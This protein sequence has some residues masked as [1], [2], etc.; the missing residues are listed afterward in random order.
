VSLIGENVRLKKQGRRWVGLCPFH[1]ERTPSFSV[2]QERGLYYCFGCKAAGSAVDYLMQLEGM[3]FPE[4]IRALAERANI[5]IEESH[6]SG[7]Q[8]RAKQKRREKEELFNLNALCA[9]FFERQLREHPLADLAWEEIRR[10]GLDPEDETCAEALKAFR[11]GYA[12]YGWDGLAR[13]L[14]RQGIEP[15]RAA[16][17]GV[18]SAR[19]SGGGFFDAFRHRLMFAVSDKSGRVVAFSGRALKEPEAEV[20]SEHGIEPLFRRPD[21]ERRDPPKY[22]N[23]PESPI[24]VK[25]DNV[26]GL[27][28]ARRDVRERGQAV[29]VEGN[30]DVLSLHARGFRLA[31]APLGTAFTLGQARLIKRYA[32]TAVV[33]FDADKAGKKA[34]VAMRGPARE[35]GLS[36]LVV[37]LPDGMDPDD[38]ARQNGVEAAEA[39]VKGARG[40]LEFMVDELIGNQATFDDHSRRGVLKRI[41]RVAE[42]I[43]EESDGDMRLMAK[44]YADEVASRVSIAGTTAGGLKA[45]ERM[46]QQAMRN[47]D[48]KQAR[49]LSA[50]GSGHHDEQGPPTGRRE[51]NYARDKK[52]AGVSG[53]SRARA[54]DIPLNILGAILDFPE[55]L[56]ESEVEGC[57]AELDGAVAL[58]VAA[59]RQVWDA[60][61]GLEGPEIL[62]LLPRAIHSFA[63]GRLAAPRFNDRE[64]ALAGLLDNAKILRRRSLT[65]DNAA[66]VQELNRADA[67]GD[68]DAQDE[69]LREMARRAK[70]KVRL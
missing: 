51:F 21:P 39:A 25:G 61:K 44:A 58:A 14:E 46:M 22:I 62:D 45:L 6:D 41:R 5:E 2:N 48:R 64:E 52:L 63:V 54:D 34:T 10:R 13:Y 8:E 33:M 20:L 59:V 42:L 65:G 12:P 50:D 69:L 26:F 40:M 31:V 67:L 4:A 49:K 56:E 1:K 60:K 32:P 35:G 30:F 68:T 38:Y 47:H 53:R 28:Q 3:T 27:Y 43:A 7:D 36:L 24:Y 19:R 57:L 17:L 23:S 16:E 9:D 55:L 11:I 37:S 18:V 15:R 66:K 70:E 29:L